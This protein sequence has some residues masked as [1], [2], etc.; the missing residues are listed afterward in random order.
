MMKLLKTIKKPGVIIPIVLFLYLFS[1]YN[2]ACSCATALRR[3]R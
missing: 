2:S 1:A 3:V